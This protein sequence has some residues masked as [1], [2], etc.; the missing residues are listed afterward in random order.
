MLGSRLHLGR[1]DA[2]DHLLALAQSHCFSCAQ[3]GLETA[4]ITQLAEL[5]DGMIHI[6]AQTKGLTP[7]WNSRG[8]AG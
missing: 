4:R 6:V 7:G 3:P 5:T 2:A 1:D 8:F